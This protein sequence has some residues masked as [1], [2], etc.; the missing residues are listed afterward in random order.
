MSN[1]L[2][3]GVEAEG[4]G[5]G[6][7]DR[8]PTQAL[9]TTHPGRGFSVG[10]Q[11]ACKTQFLHSWRR[12]DIRTTTGSNA[13][14]HCGAPSSLQSQAGKPDLGTMYTRLQ[15]I[16][17]QERSTDETCIVSERREQQADMP[18]LFWQRTPD[19]F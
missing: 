10:Q 11:V 12:R 16:S 19:T 3:G 14:W 17:R 1:P 5:V 18:I 15:T 8:Q 9:R 4:F 6:I 2:L 13:S 7:R